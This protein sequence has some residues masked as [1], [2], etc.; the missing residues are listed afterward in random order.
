[1]RPACCTNR[2]SSPYSVGVSFT[3]SPRHGHASGPAGPRESLPE[4][5]TSVRLLGRVVADGHPHAG[6]QLSRVERLDHVVIRAGVE[7]PH[8]LLFRVAHRQDDDGHRG[9]RAQL[10]QHLCAVTV[11]ESEVQE[12]DVGFLC[13][14]PSAGLPLPSARRARRIPASR[15]SRGGGGGSAPR[16]R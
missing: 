12:D 1:M 9:P 7:E 2:R 6:D 4:T 14:A 16:R 8:D 3:G 15:G 11:G 13:P 5:K 10:G